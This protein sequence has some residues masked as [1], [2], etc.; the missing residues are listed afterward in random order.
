MNG[1]YGSGGKVVE[2]GDVLGRR[3]WPEPKPYSRERG[4]GG[5]E[6][7]GARTFI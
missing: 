1:G 4:V 6:E 3:W 5:G 2:G 7:S